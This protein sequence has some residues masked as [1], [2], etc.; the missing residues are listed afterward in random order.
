MR[1]HRMTLGELHK[2][3][4]QN[5]IN[6]QFVTAWGAPYTSFSILVGNDSFSLYIE[7]DSFF[8]YKDF[9][10]LQNRNVLDNV[11]FRNIEIDKIVI[12]HN[13]YEYRKRFFFI[14]RLD[15]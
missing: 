11:L 6:Y 5:N 13:S 7:L 14:I 3:L 8:D 10:Y 4:V 2:L 1:C 12:Y 15:I 9:V